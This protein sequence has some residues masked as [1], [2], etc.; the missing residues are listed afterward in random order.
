MPR[1]DRSSSRSRGLRPTRPTGR[2][3]LRLFDRLALLR[4]GRT[5][6]YDRVHAQ[7]SEWL[8]SY[9]LRTQKWGP[10]FEDIGAYS[11]TQINAG[12]MV[13]YILDNPGWDGRWQEKA[14]ATL[15]WVDRRLGNTFWKRFGVFATN[16]Q[17]AYE[18]PGNSHTSR[19]ASLRA[20]ARREDG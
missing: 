19:Q 9:P 13:Q 2:A 17:T 16:E 3:T 15:D 6:D 10:F 7:V 4:V 20:A 11:D 18:V 8:R 14:A 12:T 5:D 1:A